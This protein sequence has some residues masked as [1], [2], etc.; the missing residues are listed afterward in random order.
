MDALLS[1]TCCLSQL[2]ALCLALI[3]AISVSLKKDPRI[4]E[5]RYKVMV[6]RS[7]YRERMEEY[8]RIKYHNWAKTIH[9]LVEMPPADF[10]RHIAYIFQEMGYNASVVGGSGDGGIDVIASKDGEKTVVQ[11][12]RYAIDRTISS[13]E[14]RN[15][16]GAMT[17]SQA[18]K[19]YFVTT[20]SFT[21]P[22]MDEAEMIPELYLID[23][24]GIV[25]WWKA[26]K[27]GPYKDEIIPPEQPVYP[28]KPVILPPTILGFRVWQ[29]IVLVLL[30]ETAI[31][32]GVLV[33]FAFLGTAR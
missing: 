33:I 19:G 9:D 28:P 25:A 30:G 18:T 17:V 23:G 21:K 24:D 29:W 20:A 32:V 27:I 13:P 5:Y 15:F 3:P 1:C 22:A 31:I 16:I 8:E 2:I 12:K 14:L 11:C 10:E 26:F 4:E 6:L 7:E